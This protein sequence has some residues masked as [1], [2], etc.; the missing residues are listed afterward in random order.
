M[1]GTKYLTN[2]NS[3][4]S[5]NK[6][7][8]NWNNYYQPCFADK[9][10]RSI[11]IQIQTVW[12][13]GLCSRLGCSIASTQ[14][15]EP[16]GGVLRMG[17]DSHIMSWRQS[18]NVLGWGNRQRLWGR[19]VALKNQEETGVIKIGERGPRWEKWGR[20]Q[21][22]HVWPSEVFRSL[23]WGAVLSKRVTWFYFVF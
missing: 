21:L 12:L 22:D 8:R 19:R 14:R 6:P 15:R 5:H 3:H 2:I 11:W 13:Q 18:M 9:E 23:L 17:K 20:Q 10:T 1:P 16:L 4:N 7:M